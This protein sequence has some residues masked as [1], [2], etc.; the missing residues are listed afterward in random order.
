MEKNENTPKSK[1]PEADTGNASNPSPH[2]K[3]W[4]PVKEQLLND[5]AETYL[6]ESGNIEDE[7]DA[8]D[9]F[10]AEQAIKREE[11]P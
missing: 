3:S 7:P 2:D 10:D 9:E 8:Q 1:A 4:D 11:N 5:K 6:R